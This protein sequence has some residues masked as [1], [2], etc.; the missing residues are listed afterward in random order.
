MPRSPSPRSGPPGAPGRSPTHGRSLTGHQLGARG[1]VGI[2]D[3]RDR[4]EDVVDVYVRGPKGRGVDTRSPAKAHAQRTPIWLHQRSVNVRLELTRATP[5]DRI[6]LARCVSLQPERCDHR[7][8]PIGQHEVRL[9]V[10]IQIGR[11]IHGVHHDGYT[12]AGH[13][14]LPQFVEV[15]ANRKRHVQQVQV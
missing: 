4:H 3:T 13:R 12:R 1:S 15:A 8:Q 14:D 2:G 5:S 7:P 6:R 9:D 11:E 10:T